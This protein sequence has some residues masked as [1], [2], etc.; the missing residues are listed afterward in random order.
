MS[1]LGLDL[2]ILCCVLIL[3]AF[4][5]LVLACLFEFVRLIV[6][7]PFKSRCSYAQWIT[8]ATLGFCRHIATFIVFCGCLRLY[9]LLLCLLR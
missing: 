3:K 2:D 1:I 7:L 8:W 4:V 5:W 6:F 9:L